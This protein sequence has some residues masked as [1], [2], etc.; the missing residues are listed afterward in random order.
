MNHA[1]LVVANDH[2]AVN[3]ACALD[4]TKASAMEW[5]R[6]ARV[7][8]DEGEYQLFINLT[9]RAGDEVAHLR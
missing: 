1:N 7:A 3:C 9:K 8:L 6:R 5:L 4:Q 2:A